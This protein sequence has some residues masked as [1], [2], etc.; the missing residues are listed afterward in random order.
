MQ[1][2]GCF[3]F[4][5]DPPVSAPY[6]SCPAPTGHLWTFPRRRSGRVTSPVRKNRLTR[7][8]RMHQR[9]ICVPVQPK[10]ADPQRKSPPPAT[11]NHPTCVMPD[12]I[13]HLSP[14][15]P[16][17]T[18]ARARIGPVWCSSVCIY[19]VRAPNVGFWCSS[20][21]NQ[22]FNP[23]DLAPKCTD[24]GAVLHSGRQRQGFSGTSQGSRKIPVRSSPSSYSRGCGALLTNTQWP[25]RRVLRAG[26]RVIIHITLPL[27]CHPDH[28][29][30]S[31]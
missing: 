2:P 14:P 12:L 27:T 22:Y 13:G 11:Q 21:E 20:T 31:S 29:S 28:S 4:P 5:S 25:A 8:V 10:N 24:T 6:S 7:D 1:K 19:R 17:R 18:Q 26:S 23:C 9:P 15:A 16:A 30:L 3:S